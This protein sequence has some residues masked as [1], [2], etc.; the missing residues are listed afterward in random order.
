MG[1]Q[2]YQVQ[3]MLSV[4]AD[5]VDAPP[6]FR[7]G[8]VIGDFILGISKVNKRLVSLTDIGRVRR[9]GQVELIV[10]AVTV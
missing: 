1:T 10:Q 7:S 8:V 5:D 3:A 6:G 9:G 4:N 2:A